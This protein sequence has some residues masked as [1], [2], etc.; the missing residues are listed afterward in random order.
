MIK[1]CEPGIEDAEIEAAVG[2]IKSGWL[3]HGPYNVEFEKRFA[4]F[5]GVKHALTCN[6]CTSALFLALKGLGVTGEVIIPSFTFVATAN[7]VVTA[8]ATP[9]FVDIDYQTCNI[10]PEKVREAITD[11]TEAVIIV[12]FAGQCADMDPLMAI[13]GE[14]DLHVIED[15]AECIG[16]TYKDKKAGQF[17][18]G[19]F[20]FFPTKNITTGEG[21]MVT[22]DDDHLARRL[23][24]LIGHGI[25]SNTYEREKKAKPWYRSAIA[26]GYNFRM[27]NILAAIGVEQMKRLNMMNQRR[28][29]LSTKLLE[30][31][32]ESPELD[33]PYPA[34]S[35][36]HVYQ[37]FTI[38]VKNSGIRDELVK[39]LNKKGVAASVHFDPPVHQQGY[40][41]GNPAVRQGSLA[42]TEKAA[43]SIATLPMFP[44]LTEENVKTIGETTLISLEALDFQ[45][46]G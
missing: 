14:Y 26:A 35:R 24:A 29:D 36:R 6:S 32:A 25:D 18:I 33:L 23:K 30:I 39:T 17:G 27:S 5:I 46:H 15:A 3:A 42:V 43:K 40:Y 44:G 16:G 12:H 45:K 31:L 37:M 4:D 10:D 21:G 20:S 7:A 1:L 19:C 13:A 34:E 11:K 41:M 9:V 22:T 38:K 2:A 28:I 8:G